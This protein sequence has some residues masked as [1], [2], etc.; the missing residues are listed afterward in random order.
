MHGQ[1]V[2]SINDG[3]GTVLSC[4]EKISP[5]LRSLYEGHIFQEL[6]CTSVSPK[7]SF[8]TQGYLKALLVHFLSRNSSKFEVNNC[9]KPIFIGKI[10]S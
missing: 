7:K 2:L 4:W 8:P 6:N 5:L 1:V 3:P 10:I 9:I